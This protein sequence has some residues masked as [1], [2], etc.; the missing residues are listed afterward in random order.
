MFADLGLQ[1]KVK[2]TGIN[3]VDSEIEV[4]GLE[5]R[6][7]SSRFRVSRFGFRARVHDLGFTFSM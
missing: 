5:F 4:Y 7:S 6:N 1:F 2:V 3:G